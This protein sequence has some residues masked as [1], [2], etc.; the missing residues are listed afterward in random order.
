MHIVTIGINRYQNCG[1]LGNAVGDAEGTFK[2]FSELGFR[3]HSMLLDEEATGSAMRRLV[4][5]DLQ[6]LGKEDSLVLFFAGHG[7]T[8]KTEFADTSCIK[9]GYLVPVDGD[10][11]RPGTCIRIRTWLDE[12]AHLQ[13]KHILVILDACKSGIALDTMHRWHASVEHPGV[14]SPL[15][16]LRQRRSR[17]VFTSALDD[18]LASDRGPRAGNSLFTGFLIQALEEGLRTGREAATGSMIWSYVQEHVMMHPRSRQTPA[19]GALQLHDDGD[20]VVPL[21]SKAAVEVEGA[22][23]KR[24]SDEHTRGGSSRSKHKKVGTGTKAGK[25]SAAGK[26]GPA[27]RGRKKQSDTADTRSADL[28]EEGLDLSAADEEDDVGSEEIEEGPAELDVRRSSLVAARPPQL[29]RTSVI[30]R[31]G[32][33][34]LDARLVAAL[35]RQASHR[36]QGAPTLSTIAGPADEAAAAI[37]TYHAQRGALTLITS[38]TRIDAAIADVLH[39]MPWPRCLAAAR[40]ALCRAARIETSALEAHLEARGG[41]ERRQWIDDLSSG[42]PAVR[43]A[44]WLLTHTRDPREPYDLSTAPV[45][46]REL[47][48]ALG[49]L[50]CPIAVLVHHED[51]TEEWLQDAVGVAASLTT[52]LPWHPVSLSAPPEL[53]ARVLEGGRDSGAKAMGRQGRVQAKARLG[54]VGAASPT[55]L[56][57]A[58]LEERLFHALEADPRAR[59]RFNRH[60]CAPIYERER[61]VPVM[62]AARQECLLVDVDRWYHVRDPDEHR[63]TRL[64]DIWLQRAGFLSLRFPAEDLEHRLSSVVD[65]ICAGLAGRRDESLFL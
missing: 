39:Q 23:P 57:E 50:L 42:N 43:V 61:A 22:T 25:K 65:E 18:E 3:Q 26:K 5:E 49:D 35:D 37:A 63:K 11:K 62:L 31:E 47:L 27:K 55:A 13:A 28:D 59:G 64:K 48:T 38:A 24:E 51:P 56:D 53:L 41:R 4:E 19:L 6:S 20:I 17:R 7:Y 10:L 45:Q 12:I 30:L 21:P 52:H 1:K 2:I 54:A 44:G 8:A 29:H 46:G 40:T 58:F 14:R 34:I 60:I 15:D 33:G 36:K 32:A 16:R 9:T